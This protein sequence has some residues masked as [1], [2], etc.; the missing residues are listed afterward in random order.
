MSSEMSER[1]QAT[2]GATESLFLDTTVPNMVRIFDYL[3]GGS[4]HFEADRYAAERMLELIPSLRKWV[5]L[6]RAFI[7]EAALALYEEGF[8]QF[9]D[10]GS[11]IPAEDHIHASISDACIIYSD[12]NPVAVAYGSSLFEDLENV[13]YIFGDARH[14]DD[15]LFSPIV[16]QLID[17]S[18]KVAIGLNALTL[19]L[20]ENE[21]AELANALFD[22]AP[23]GS[24][25]FVVFQT[26]AGADAEDRYQRFVTMTAAAG[27]PLQIRSLQRNREMLRP[28]RCSLLE[29]I[30]SFLGLPEDLISSADREGIAMAFYAAF[31]SK[32]GKFT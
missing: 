21:T 27:L 12:I 23:A 20:S 30:T 22:W 7:Q 8:R 1:F 17:H 25:I 19:F 14:V 31:L 2:T 32:E 18:Q 10:L 3:S 5:R 28:W 29:P 13:S 15:I 11:G 26:S 16:R 6:R 4:T 24:K 9:L